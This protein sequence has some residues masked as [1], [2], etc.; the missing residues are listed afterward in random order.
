MNYHLTWVIAFGLL[1]GCVTRSDIRGLQ[2]DLYGIQRDLQANLGSVQDQ[3][4]TVQTSQADLL[5]NIHELSTSLSMLKSELADSQGRMKQLSQ[6]LDDLDASLS[7]R[8]DAQIELLSGSKFTQAPLPS[9]LF[10]LANADFSRSRYAEAIKGFQS[11]LKAA[12]RGEQ[13]AEAKLKIADSFAR[14]KQNNEALAAYDDVIKSFA[15]DPLAATAMFR[16]AQLQ[17]TSSPIAA[18]KT[19]EQLIKAH[20]FRPEAAMAG[21]RVNAIKSDIKR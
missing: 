17:E 6:R 2:Q 8:M 20:P 18:I 13:V 19:Y 12:P 9:T 10:S 7:A 4:D 21:E 15:Q 11:Y 3:T 16:K 1:S 5:T 14:Q